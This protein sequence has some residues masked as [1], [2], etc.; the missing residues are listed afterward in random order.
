[1]ELRILGCG[2]SVHVLVPWRL[3][4]VKVLAGLHGVGPSTPL[5]GDTS[6]HVRL[7]WHGL[8]HV[9][10][11]VDGLGCWGGRRQDNLRLVGLSSVLSLR[12]W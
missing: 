7:S 12:L 3:L 5:T 11:L 6:E 4:P 10:V 2:G 9:V 1:M 8:W